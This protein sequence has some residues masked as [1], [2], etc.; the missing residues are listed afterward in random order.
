MRRLLPVLLIVTFAL[1]ASAQ[2]LIPVMVKITAG[3]GFFV[4]HDGALI[5]NAHVVKNCERISVK[6]ADGEH[7]ATL[8]DADTG[9]DLALLRVD[10]AQPAA[11]AALR[12]N[13]RDLK[14]GDEVVVMGYPG[15]E[16][17]N[18]RDAFRK[19]TVLGLNG[20]T[21]EPQWIQ[22]QSVA[23]HGNSGGPVLDAA[24]NV[25]AVITG[26]AMTYR[27]YTD[28]STG[29]AVRD[30][31]LVGKSDIAITL[32][33]L[34]AFLNDNRVPYNE[35]SSGLVMHADDDL[36]RLSS[37]FIVPVRCYPR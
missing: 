21:G 25:I 36:E 16:G 11:V 35:S 34:E 23:E 6:M 1:P 24:G 15:Q 28:A 5:T 19:T 27:T 2:Q 29:K 20:P 30:P 12:W 14:A 26:N 10:H 18:G 13:I 9:K 32:P 37:G 3:T 7:A 22:L 33:V 8:A 17:V 31:E 4:T